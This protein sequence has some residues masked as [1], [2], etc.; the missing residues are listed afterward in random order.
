MIVV[1]LPDSTIA[2]WNYGDDAETLV[3]PNPGY[4]PIDS[5]VVVAR[6]ESQS[7]EMPGWDKRHEEIPLE[8][9]FN[10]CIDYSCYP[11]LRLK[12]EE[13]SHLRTL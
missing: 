3:D 5:V 9:H 8:T 10:N 2:G 12:L 7:E 11:S 13:P 4:P 6:L 1:K